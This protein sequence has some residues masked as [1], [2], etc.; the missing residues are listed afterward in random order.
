MNH[1]AA[2]QDRIL[3]LYEQARQMADSGYGWEDISKRLDL[4]PD[5]AKAIVL[6]HI[7]TQRRKAQ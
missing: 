4:P 1:S 5:H 7:V 6:G 3:A 2:E